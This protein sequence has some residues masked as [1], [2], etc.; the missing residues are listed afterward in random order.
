MRVMSLQYPA[1]HTIQSAVPLCCTTLLLSTATTPFIQEIGIALSFALAGE[2][3]IGAGGRA[4]WLFW[5]GEGWVCTCWKDVKWNHRRWIEGLS[6]NDPA[7][8]FVTRRFPTVW[9]FHRP[10]TVHWTIIVCLFMSKARLQN[11]RK[12]GRSSPQMSARGRNY[13]C[14]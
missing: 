7:P 8:A 14:C 3:D 4:Y 2:G 12:L 11:T 9:K 10:Q 6:K 13:G 1:S 5:R